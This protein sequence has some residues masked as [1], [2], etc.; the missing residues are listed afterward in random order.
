MEDNPSMHTDNPSL[1]SLIWAVF[2]S[3]GE[4]N[5]EA[6]SYFMH[7]Q[8][9]AAAIIHAGLI[10]TRRRRRRRPC[11]RPTERAQQQQQQLVEKGMFVVV[12]SSCAPRLYDYSR[13]IISNSIQMTHYKKPWTGTV[14]PLCIFKSKKFT[15]QLL[16]TIKK[17]TSKKKIGQK[18][19]KY[20]SKLIGRNQA[21]NCQ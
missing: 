10:S 4:L 19:F 18:Y 12:S 21:I 15:I 9:T 11:H 5:V 1:Y 16:S 20:F 17:K 3:K 7:C 2:S 14:Q 6:G 8:P 13:E